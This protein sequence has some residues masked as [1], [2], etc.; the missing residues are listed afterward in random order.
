[1]K[2]K[3]IQITEASSAE[4]GIVVLRK[5]LIRLVIILSLIA[6]GFFL[7]WA[8]QGHTLLIVNKGLNHDG[9]DYPGLGIVEITIDGEK[10]VE[11]ARLERIKKDLAGATHRIRAEIVGGRGIGTVVETEL[12]LGKDRV[13]ILSLP[14]LLGGLEYN[15][16]LQVFIPPASMAPQAREPVM[17]GVQGMEAAKP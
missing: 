7:A 12:T 5:V 3:P 15:Q 10:P 1:M 11:I 17:S 9:V 16:W 8:G 13:W 14:G 4:T 2:D 6:L